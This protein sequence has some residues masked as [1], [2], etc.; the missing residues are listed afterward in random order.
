MMGPCDD[1]YKDLADTS[2]AV[3][4]ILEVGCVFVIR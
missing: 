4:N 2:F 3:F 1:S